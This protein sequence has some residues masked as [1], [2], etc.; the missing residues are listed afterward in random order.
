[1]KAEDNADRCADH[2]SEAH[3]PSPAPRRQQMERSST[4]RFDSLLRIKTTPDGL[5][6]GR[7]YFLR[8]PSHDACERIIS[9]LSKA[10]D[11]A[12]RRL[13]VLSR[14]QKSQEVARV[15]FFSAPFQTASCLLI[16][17]VVIQRA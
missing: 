11:D 17:T 6:S 3:K 13:H 16:F 9:E 1:M 7:T 8:A 2:S 15:L 10:A 12:K 4:I 14:F 5:N